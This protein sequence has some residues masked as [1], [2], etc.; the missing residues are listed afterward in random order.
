VIHLVGKGAL[1]PLLWLCR[2]GF[3]DVA[4]LSHGRATAEP[5]DLLVLLEASEAAAFEPQALSHVRPGGVAIVRIGHPRGALTSR[6]LR[7]HGF[8][9]ERRLRHGRRDVYVARR[10]ASA[11]R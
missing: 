1:A 9:I 8:R 5:A 2:H 11:G 6:L 10:E 3:D 4:M 7:R